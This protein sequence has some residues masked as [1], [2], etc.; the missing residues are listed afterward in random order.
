MLR[1]YGLQCWRVVLA[2][3]MERESDMQK[4]FKTVIAPIEQRLHFHQS[5]S[6]LSTGRVP[7]IEQLLDEQ[8]FYCSTSLPE[9]IFGAAIVTASCKKFLF[10]A[11]IFLLQK[12]TASVQNA[13]GISIYTYYAN[14]CATYMHT[15]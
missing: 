13:I 8:D 2:V 4:L 9:S 12:L 15:A 10:A 6:S 3:D 5:L 11:Y 7:L 14:C 1:S